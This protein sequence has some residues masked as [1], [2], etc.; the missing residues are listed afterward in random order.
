MKYLAYFDLLEFW[1]WRQI[2]TRLKHFKAFAEFK[3]L[4]ALQDDI[5]LNVLRGLQVKVGGQT[6]RGRDTENLEAYL[7]VMQG[8][9]RI[10][11]WSKKDN[12]R[13]R[14][15]YKEAIALDP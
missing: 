1:K 6:S 8:L 5:A 2:V 14:Q 13:A 7:K 9:N 4:F 12:A 3:N 15:F 10:G 11:H